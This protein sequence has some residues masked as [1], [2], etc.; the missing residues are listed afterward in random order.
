MPA[1]ENE[2]TPSFPL[3]LHASQEFAQLVLQQYP[4]THP[5]TVPQT[6][7][8]EPWQSPPATGLHAA[9]CAFCGWQVPPLAQYALAMHPLSPA[10][11]VGQLKCVPSHR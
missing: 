8:V 2:Q 1:G 10:Q 4:S 5:P 3:R 7:Q 9:L 11:T 6:R